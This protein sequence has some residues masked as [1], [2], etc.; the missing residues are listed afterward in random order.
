MLF[1]KDVVSRNPG[2]DVV[3]DVKC[4]RHLNSIISGFGGR[5]EPGEDIWE[6]EQSEAGQNGEQPAEEYC[7]GGD[8]IDHSVT[9][10]SIALATTRVPTKATRATT[11]IT[12]TNAVSPVRTM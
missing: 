9:C 11:T 6:A 12:G 4:T 7:N 10:C 2:S 5:M 1:A 3:Y 8:Q